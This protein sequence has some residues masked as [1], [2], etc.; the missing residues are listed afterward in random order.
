MQTLLATFLK[1]LRLLYRDRSGLLVL[2]VMPAV[3]VVVVA[4]VQENV[5]R[6]TGAARMEILFVDQD[7]QA[8]G[9]LIGEQLGRLD[10]VTLVTLLD[11]QALDTDKVGALVDQ[12]RYQAGIVV[13]AGV[14][15]EVR[16]RAAEQISDA[17]SGGSGREAPP[18]PRVS[19]YFDPLV[20]GA[21]K[22]S[23]LNAL[24]QILLTMEME[25]KAR[26]LAEALPAHLQQ[27]LG[28]LPIDPASIPAIHIDPGWGRRRLLDVAAEQ[29]RLKKLP[30]SVQQ[31]VSAWSVFG[32]FFIVLPLGGTII[33]ERKDGTLSRLRTLPVPYITLLAG[34]LGAFVAVCWVQFLFIVLMGKE[35][36]PL[37]GTPVLSLGSDTTALV[38]TVTMVALAAC[39]YGLAVGTSARTL[40]QASM[41]GAVSVVCAA[42]LGGIMVPVY[43]M[44]PAMQTI[45]GFSPL[46]W[47][48]NALVEISVREGTLGSIRHELLWLAAFFAATMAIAW[49]RFSRLNR[50]AEMQGG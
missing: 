30:T 31:N 33:R 50:R 47:G 28:R 38:V 1:E 26:A 40:E 7:R 27:A 12:G 37:M 23:L 11:G 2:F 19:V 48:L 5:M 34:K 15:A 49:I 43:I 20:Q 22:A 44:P 21:Y 14:T 3:L 24:K 25:L 29:S 39:G 4:L 8:L 41:F 42:A 10:G 36:L 16:A 46:A 17:F 6:A 45:S 9:T 32:I 13:P 35:L 18:V